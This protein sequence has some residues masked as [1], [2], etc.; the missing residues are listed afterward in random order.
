MHPEPEADAPKDGAAIVPTFDVRNCMIC[1]QPMEPRKCKYQ[2]RKCGT[3][4]DCSDP[5]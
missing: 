4:I 2:C 1:G 3:M 5:Y